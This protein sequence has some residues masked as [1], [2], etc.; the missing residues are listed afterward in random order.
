VIASGAV[1]GLFLALIHITGRNRKRTSN[2]ILSALLVVLS[3]SILHSLLGSPVFDSP[4]KIREPFILLIGPL[5]SFYIYDLT[6]IRKHT[7]KDILHALPFILLMLL[8]MP[9]WTRK[10]SPYTD[11]LFTHGLTISKIIWTLIV[12]QYGYY[13]WNILAVLKKHRIAVESEFSD[14]EGKTLSWLHIFLHIFGGFLLLLV[15]TLVITF[16]TNNY[17]LVDTI[18][19]LGLSTAI[20]VLGYCGLSQDE[21]FSSI[22]SHHEEYQEEKF[23]ASLP[24]KSG[25]HIV[26]QNKELLH[27]LQAHLETTKPYLYEALTLT[28]LARQI[29]M[30]RNQLSF[31][32]NSAYGENFY[33]F[34]NNFRVEE[35]KRLIA[36]PKNKNFTILSLADEAGFPSKSSFQAIFKKFTGLTPTEYRKNLR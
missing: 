8:L 14:L 29:G 12:L 6:G 2:K 31:L 27:K 11:F 24:S 10:A 20:F 21:I 36:D 32:I 18:V 23:Q 22:P 3:I 13:W 33:A 25:E 16:H 26:K 17:D 15:F 4:Y 1:Q 35:V 5:L 30:T 7:W 28:E 9:I 19:C 34:I